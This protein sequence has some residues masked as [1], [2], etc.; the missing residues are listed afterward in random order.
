MNDESKRR[1]SDPSK[2]AG[3]PEAPA[4]A[5][6]ESDSTAEPGKGT[7]KSRDPVARWT[8]NLLILALLLFAWY[9]A[10]DRVAPWTDQARVDGFIVAI[11]PKVS[12]KVKEVSVVQ[13]QLVQAGDVLAKIDPRP[14]ELAVQRTAPGHYY[15][16]ASGNWKQK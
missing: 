9:I 16:D 2:D 12:G 14:Y 1:S 11:T 5:Q 13:D 15:Q 10:A 3:A 7:S 6:S 4:R 8:R